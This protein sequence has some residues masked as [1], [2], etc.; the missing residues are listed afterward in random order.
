MPSNENA[1]DRFSASFVGMRFAFAVHTV[2]S[3]EGQGTAKGD[4]CSGD[5]FRG[6]TSRLG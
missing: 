5:L 2:V 6:E 3:E 4:Q 1:S